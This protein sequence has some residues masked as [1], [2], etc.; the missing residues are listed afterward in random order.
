MR[1]AGC[2]RCRRRLSSGFQPLGPRR[3]VQPAARPRARLARA[4][5]EARTARGAGNRPR[6][7][8]RGGF[9]P[10]AL[11][12]RDGQ[13]RRRAAARRDPRR[14]CREALRL[15]GHAAARGGRAEGRFFTRR[16]RAPGA[17]AGLFKAL[18]GGMG[19]L[20]SA[21]ESRLPAGSVRCGPARRPSRSPLRWQVVTTDVTIAARAVIL[22]APAHAAARL[23]GR[24]AARGALR[25]GAVRLDRERG[26]RVAACQRRSSPGRQRLRRRPPA[27][28]LRISACTWVSSKWQERAR[29]DMVLLRAFLGGAPDPGARSRR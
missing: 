14:R 24:C 13:P 28:P 8:V 6:R 9:L 25:R 2:T 22:A 11:R 29:P 17:G 10:P 4:L 18:R 19:E 15:G 21:I 5:G 3:R 7:R 12:P 27:Q 26:A 16:R 20:V 1:T 23:L